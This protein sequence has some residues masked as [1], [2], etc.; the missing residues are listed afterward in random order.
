MVIPGTEASAASDATFTRW[1]AAPAEHAGDGLAA[2]LERDGEVQLDLGV[3]LLGRALPQRAL[4]GEAG[5]VHQHV[6]RAGFVLDAV[7]EPVALLRV[8]Q[9]GRVGGAAELGGQRVEGRT[10]AGDQRHRRA[11]SRERGGEG[12]TDA[13]RR[14]GDQHPLAGQLHGVPLVSASRTY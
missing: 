2:Q 6:D 5:V 12:A 3:D 14:A 7:H 8:E 10:V 13:P 9:V 1:P 4:V 11:G